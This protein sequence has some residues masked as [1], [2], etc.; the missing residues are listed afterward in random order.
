[1]KNKTYHIL[2]YGDSGEQLRSYTVTK[3]RLLFA[4]TA[5]VLYGVFLATLLLY[6]F[7][8][9]TDLRHY[10]AHRSYYDSLA[11]VDTRIDSLVGQLIEINRYSQYIRMAA[12]TTGDSLMPTLEEYFSDEELIKELSAAGMD[13]DFE[14]VPSLRPVM[15]AVSQHFS[16][17]HPAIDISASQGAM[18]RATASGVVARKYFHEYLGNVIEIDHSNGYVSLY[19]H[20]ESILVNLRSR[21]TKGDPIALVGNTGKGSRGPHLHFAIEKDGTP[22]DPKKMV[23]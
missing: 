2:V 14:Y 18:I 1:M 8:H 3:G 16:E 4:K 19:A 9:A 23:F 5:L 13:T 7:L 15:G 22:V 11:Y 10:R 20:C 21:V 6:V 12:L 17:E